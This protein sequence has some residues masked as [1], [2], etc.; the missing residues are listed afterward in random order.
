[1]LQEV[2]LNLENPFLLN[3]GDFPVRPTKLSN[4]A[5]RS[6]QYDYNDAARP[7]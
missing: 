1:M 5:D 2:S 3:L 7:P 4:D 6:V